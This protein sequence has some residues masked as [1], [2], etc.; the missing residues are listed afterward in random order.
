VTTWRAAELGPVVDASGGV[1]RTGPFGA[2]LHRSDYTL[3]PAG[4][5][6]VMPKDMAGGCVDLAGIARVDERKL[7]QLADHRLTAGDIVL[8]RRGDIGRCAWIGER[9]D[10]YLCGTG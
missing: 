9:E 7:R 5:P 3:G 4:T 8:A 1:V 10:G 6:V 2:Q